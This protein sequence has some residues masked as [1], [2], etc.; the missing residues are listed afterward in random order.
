MLELCD[1]VDMTAELDLEI[2]ELLDELDD[3]AAD[4]E[5]KELLR[6]EDVELDADADVGTELDT[7]VEED[8]LD[9]ATVLEE[10]TLDED[11][12]VPRSS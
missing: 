4:D 5:V 8:K 10:T 3:C 11:G 7:R 6:A 1:V 2:A 9:D 12:V